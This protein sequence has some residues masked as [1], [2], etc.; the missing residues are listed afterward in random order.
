MAQRNTSISRDE[1]QKE[2]ENPD[3]D[4]P[5]YDCDRRDTHQVSKPYFGHGDPNADVLLLGADPGGN[6]SVTEDTDVWYNHKRFWKDYPGTE[7]EVDE[8]QSNHKDDFLPI[9]GVKES[10]PEL[11]SII[12]KLEENNLSVYYTNV[13]KCNHINSA[14]EDDDVTVPENVNAEIEDQD[15]LNRAGKRNCASNFLLGEVRSVDPDVIIVLADGSWHINYVF[16]LFSLDTPSGENVRDYVWKHVSGDATSATDVIPVHN[17]DRVQS[18]IIPTYHF[19]MI[20]RNVSRFLNTKGN[21]LYG[22]ELS[23]PE[24]GGKDWYYDLIMDRVTG[25]VK[26]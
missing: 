3:P 5:C 1:I 24:K 21:E 18:I 10:I 15:E 19:N 16:E 2:W 6:S 17:S 13:A 23:P 26:E 9:S 11:A 22:S 14:I 20:G 12:T 25:L 8:Y 7:E 4:S